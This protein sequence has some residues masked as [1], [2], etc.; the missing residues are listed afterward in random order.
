LYKARLLRDVAIEHFD[1]N[2]DR[3]EAG[4]GPVAFGLPKIVLDAQTP[5]AIPS[6]KR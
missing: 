3:G 5:I 6:I 4:P 2:A 1:W